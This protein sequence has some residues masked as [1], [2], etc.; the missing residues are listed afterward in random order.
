MLRVAG[1]VALIVLAACNQTS[2]NSSPSPTPIVAQGAWT[3]NL[4][5]SGDISG[6][7]A[8]I[9]PDIGDQRSQCTGGR[10][11]N[12]ETWADVFYGTL[13]SSGQ[14]YG[15]VFSINNFRGPGTYQGTAVT[16]EVHSADTTKVWEGLGRDKVTFSLDRGQQSGTVDATL[17]N[18]TTGKDGLQMTGSWNC[19]Q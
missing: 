2:A 19:K 7:M 8:S 9:V 6:H 13:D 3:Q 18:A 10:T 14:V 12:G 15:V 11:H 1:I 16:I 17:T 4:S 5:F